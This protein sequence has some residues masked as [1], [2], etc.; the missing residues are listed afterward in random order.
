[1]INTYNEKKESKL[2]KIFR[3]LSIKSQ[4]AI[5]NENKFNDFKKYM[6]I[7][8]PIQQD[9]INKIENHLFTNKKSIIFIVGNVGDG[10]SHILSYMSVLYK[11]EFEDLNIKIHNDATETT[12]PHKSAIETLLELLEPYND[13]DINSGENRLIIAINLGMLTKLSEELNNKGN[14]NILNKYI[15]ETN[16]LDQKQIKDNENKYF[17]IVSFIGLSSINIENNKITSNFYRQAFDKVFLKDKGNPFYNAYLFDLENNIYRDI[18]KNYELLLRKE[19]KEAIIY[20]LIRAEIEYKMIISAR[21]LFNFFYDICYPGINNKNKY[22]LLPSLLFENKNKSKLLNIISKFDPIID[23]TKEIDD[24]TIE[25]Y[26]SNDYG[27]RIEDLLKEKKELIFIFKEIPEYKKTFRNYLNLYLR[28][29]FL[30]NYND[31]IFDNKIYNEF[32]NLFKKIK[33]ENK[34]YNKCNE[35][36]LYKLISKTILKW[37]GDLGDTNTKIIKTS[38]NSNIKILIE[39][40]YEFL[41]QYILGTE[42]ILEILVK[43]QEKINLKIDFNTFKLLK[44]IEQGYFIKA[45]DRKKAVNF[46]KFINDIIKYSEQNKNSID[47]YNTKTK[48]IYKLKKE[49]WNEYT[50]KKVMN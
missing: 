27:K 37:N 2:D 26:H 45:D 8:R 12:S 23:Q 39:P 19:F 25:L 14:F 42:I 17:D 40:E 16:V 11:E 29:R 30:L 9:L 7:E 36:R 43:D 13:I 1:M 18:H 22:N 34:E 24:I 20:L 49:V 15:K 21:T 5:I 6:H 10:K 41:N 33:V 50:L 28:L 32:L 46:N 48:K 38:N 4:E 3:K 44:A 31:K 47:I 35:I